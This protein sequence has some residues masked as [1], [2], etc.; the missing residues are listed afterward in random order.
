VF[1]VWQLGSAL[2]L[3]PQDVLPAQEACWFAEG[4]LPLLKQ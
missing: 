3:I 1:G 4:V 2:G